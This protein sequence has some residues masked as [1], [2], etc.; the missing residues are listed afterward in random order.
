MLR[1]ACCR[2]QASDIHPETGQVRPIPAVLTAVPLIDQS[3]RDARPYAKRAATSRGPCRWEAPGG[4]ARL[5]DGADGPE[6]RGPCRRGRVDW[7]L[8]E[9]PRIALLQDHGRE[10]GVERVPA[11]M[12]NQV[13]DERMT[14]ERP[15]ADH[16]QQ[17]LA[18]G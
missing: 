9:R 16:L 8:D 2:P 4:P 3:I 14:E 18:P 10:F 12:C 15:V 13:T 6:R 1:S 11:T 17:P 5:V 7:N